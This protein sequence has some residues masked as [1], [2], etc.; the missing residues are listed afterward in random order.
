MKAKWMPPKRRL[1]PFYGSDMA[2]NKMRM[3]NYQDDFDLTTRQDI[4]GSQQEAA[5][6]FS[7]LLAAMATISLA[8][9]GFGIS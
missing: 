8:V 2:L 6:A 7:W 4:L 3:G 5:Q 9:G 1:P